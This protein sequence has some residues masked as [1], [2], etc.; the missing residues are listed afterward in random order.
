M[1]MKRQTLLLLLTLLVNVINAQGRIDL[2]AS[3]RGNTIQASSFEK[4]RATFSYNSVESERVATEAGE[5][6]VISLDGTV[7]G[8]NYGAPALPISRKLVAVPF[9]ATPVIKVID[10]TTVDYNLDDYGISG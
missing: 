7:A 6:S 4:I 10:Y 8:G 2:D 3:N 9:G 1:L 5:F